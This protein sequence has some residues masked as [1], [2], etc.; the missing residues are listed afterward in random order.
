MVLRIGCK[1]SGYTT[2]DLKGQVDVDGVPVSKGAV[3]FSPLAPKHG[4]G[5]FAPIQAGTYEARQVAVGRTRITFM[6][7]KETGRMT[8]S[9][10]KQVPEI[11][12]IVPPKYMGGIDVDIQAGES[13][14]NFSLD[15]K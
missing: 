2:T 1:P 8:D 10:G 14:R 7:I 6:L 13:M 11:V 15:S 4:R 3:T 5:V 9:H 12:E